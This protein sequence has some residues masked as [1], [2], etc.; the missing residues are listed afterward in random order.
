M[1]HLLTLAFLAFLS[2]VVS[3]AVAPGDKAA[4]ERISLWNK[5]APIGDGK[6]QDA[7]AFIT[8]HRPDKPNGTAIVICP[9]GGYGGLVTGPEGHGIATWLNR[10]GITGVVLE[11]RLPAGRS[12]V[13]LSDAQRALRTVRAN[14]KAWDLDPTHIG[15]M[16][17]S[18]GGHLAATAGTHF[19]AG[20]LDATD[21][22]QRVS[23]RPDFLIL[24]YPVITMGAKG[25]AGSRTNLLGKEPDAKL[26]DL[27]SNEK[28]V[29]DKTPPTFLAHAKD[30]KPVPPENSQMFYDALKA[31][32]VPAQYLELASGGHGLNGYKGAM[33]D[34]WQEGSLKWLKEMKLVPELCAT[35]A[36]AADAENEIGKVLKDKGAKV[37]ESK[38]VV[39]GLTISDGS[40]L[41]DED[42]R[43]IGSLV[44]LKTLDL[45]NGLTD[46]RLTQLTSLVELE[47]LQTNLAQVSD[48]GLKPLT[49]LKSLRNVKF[50]HPGK[51]FSGTGL[52]HLAELPNLERLTVAGSFAFN[53]EGMAAVAKLTRLQELRTWHTGVT[54]AGVKQLTTLKNLKSLYLGQ[55]LAYQ[56]PACPTD[57]T[58]AFLAEL[59]S[60]ESLQ[61]DE[62]RLTFAALQQLKRLPA[63][64]KLILGGIDIPKADVERLKQ[65][66]PGVKIEWTEPNETYQKRIR[67]LFG[68][69]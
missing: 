56:P 44:H 10:H 32:K 6:F 47:Y 35:C 12:H 60:L 16:G 20:E 54:Q 69:P 23:C 46:A 67:A 41:T 13:P 27:F 40:K 19:D 45:N 17:F 18:A 37:T 31:H 25:H 9:G 7:D 2:L 39:T 63:L 62:A 64:K 30:D 3:A 21:P 57:E 61:L 43:Q 5:R 11:Y 42:F 8:I 34:A 48:D 4:P 59:K 36:S 53:D 38:G 51:A 29:T 33:W 52:A 1:R 58:L 66:L 49:R 68:N 14:A 50:F 28:Q 15:I 24:V 22:V 55:R 65:E 26:V